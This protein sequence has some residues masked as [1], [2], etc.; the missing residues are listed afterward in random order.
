MLEVAGLYVAHVLADDVR[1]VP[2]LDDI[3]KLFLRFRWALALA[4]WEI[5]AKEDNPIG[6][7]L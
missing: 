1:M 5:E 3:D 7:A 2:I 4:R 6:A